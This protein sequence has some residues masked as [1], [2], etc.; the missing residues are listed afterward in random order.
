MAAGVLKDRIEKT[1]KHLAQAKEDLKTLK[2]RRAY[3]NE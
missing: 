3:W 2:E 1:E